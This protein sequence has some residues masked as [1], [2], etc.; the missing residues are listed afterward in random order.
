VSMQSRIL[1]ACSV[2]NRARV[3][4]L[5]VQDHNARRAVLVLVRHPG[6][7]LGQ[8]PLHQREQRCRDDR[9]QRQYRRAAVRVSGIEQPLLG[10]P[11]LSR[12]ALYPVPVVQS[13]CHHGRNGLS[14]EI[15]R[16]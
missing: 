12:F 10:L 7:V 15:R 3:D 1:T 13:R 9:Q 4:E 8:M 11:R 5:P 2:V 16:G 6:R 14:D